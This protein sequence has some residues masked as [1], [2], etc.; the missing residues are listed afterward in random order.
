MNF[1]SHLNRMLIS[2]PSEPCQCH[3]SRGLCVWQEK[4]STLG[5][6]IQANGFLVSTREPCAAAPSSL[7]GGCQ[8]PHLMPFMLLL[9]GLGRWV[10]CH[11]LGGKVAPCHCLAGWRSGPPFPVIPSGEWGQSVRFT[12][13]C[14][15]VCACVSG[16]RLIH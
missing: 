16:R 3:P 2:L 1:P 11:P 6:A 4:K 8:R 15:F 7:W 10:C 12:C 14:G 5:L 13:E 9:K